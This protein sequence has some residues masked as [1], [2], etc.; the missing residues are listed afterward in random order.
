MPV[1]SLLP[2]ECKLGQGMLSATTERLVHAHIPSRV[3][4]CE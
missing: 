1:A 2:N 4:H 3:R